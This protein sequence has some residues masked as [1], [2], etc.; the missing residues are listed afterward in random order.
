MFGMLDYRAHK[1]FWLLTLPFRLVS[2]AFYFIFVAIA[3]SIGIWTGYQ[4]PLVQI[5]TC[6]KVRLSGFGY[7]F[8]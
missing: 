2:R 6:S 1:L 4:P 5:F 7:H 8:R 3:V